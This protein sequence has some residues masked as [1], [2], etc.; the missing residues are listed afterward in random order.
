MKKKSILLIEKSESIR[1]IITLALQKLGHYVENLFIL[2]NPGELIGM[3][4]KHPI[5]LIF[6]DIEFTDFPDF[7]VPKIIKEHQ[8]SIPIYLITTSNLNDTLTQTAFQSGSQGIIR[9]FKNL[10]LLFQAM[11]TIIQGTTMNNTFYVPQ[12]DA[13]ENSQD[14]AY[15]LSELL[16]YTFHDMEKQIT[17]SNEMIISMMLE[18][19]NEKEKIRFWE[20]QINDYHR[21][22]KNE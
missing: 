19:T 22:F 11:E 1:K 16:K 8:L 21:H 18:L 5:D 14:D 10:K 7:Y 15:A 6:S 2:S 20:N 9:P 3:I 17:E 13:Q 12:I 4:K